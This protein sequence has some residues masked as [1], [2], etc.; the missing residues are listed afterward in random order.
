VKKFIFFILVLIVL[1]GCGLIGSGP[2]GET[3]PL[4]FGFQQAVAQLPATV[5]TDPIGLISWVVGLGAAVA[6]GIG[7]TIH[8]GRKIKRL[9]GQIERSSKG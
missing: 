6:A 9:S 3:A 7:G 2:G 1:S 8:Q 5:P 4:L